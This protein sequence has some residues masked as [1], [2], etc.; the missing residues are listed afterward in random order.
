MA[1][2]AAVT[3]DVAD[4]Q[5]SSRLS[6]A[7]R[8]RVVELL[9]PRMTSF[10]PHTPTT[11]QQAALLLN[12]I[13]ELLYGGAA[14][15]GKSDYLLMA[16]LQYVDVPG[17]AA[18]ILRRTFSQ[19]SKAG[20]LLLRA[21]EW[22]TGKA[23]GAETI[24]GVPTK[25]VFPSGARL[26]FGHCQHEKDRFDYQS[27][28]YTFIGFDELTQFTERIY[29]YIMSRK[30]R[31]EGFTVPLRVRAASNP[32]G[33]GH[34]FVKS[35]FITYR[36]RQRAFIPGKLSDNP[37]LDRAEYE[38]TLM[39]LHPYERQQL[40][41]GDWDV[42][43]PGSKFKREWF[44]VIDTVPAGTR[45]LTRYW[46][47][48]ATEE[49]GGNDPDWTAGAKMG[50]TPRGQYPILDMQHF[51]ASPFGVKKRM[52]QTAKLDGTSTRIWIEREP[53]ASGKF[54][55]D[56][57]IKELAGFTVRG[58]RPTGDK[59]LR[60][61][62]L[63]SQAEAGNVPLVNGPWVEPFLQELEMIDGVSK[64]HDDQGDSAAGAF[65]KVSRGERRVD[66]L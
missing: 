20:G 34:E 15:P 39:E 48:A 45:G 36:G 11:K 52:K 10:I 35:R 31:L 63:A 2:A 54:V 19:L 9:S 30:R 16:A 46:D 58:H 59:F 49:D 18:L 55:I 61:D 65:Q 12:E 22:L 53:G 66:I 14:G 43:P 28:E 37:Y 21:Q 40:L 57:F 1:E 13:P 4:L 62:P 50:R 6:T 38:K 32:G 51:R 64:V 29:L 7:Q 8:R 5:I 33:I 17:Y 56:D 26:E 44:D 41:D 3:T 25:W 42:R 60:M 24:N 23:Q 47:L 27:A